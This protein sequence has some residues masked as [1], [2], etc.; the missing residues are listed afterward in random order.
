VIVMDKTE[1]RTEFVNWLKS[2]WD[3]SVDDGPDK[4]MES[5]FKAALHS[6]IDGNLC[7]EF[8][9]TDKVIEIITNNVADI[10]AE[11]FERQSLYLSAD[12]KSATVT[13]GIGPLMATLP[14]KTL[15]D[16]TEFRET[17]DIDLEADASGCI[18][19]A[20][21]FIDAEF[22]PEELVSG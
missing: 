16:L 15:I 10:L 8:F 9:A 12:R 5:V 13:I 20:T 7:P 1:I 11:C 3:I 4:S 21:A 6:C 22:F 18:T 17:G 14:I 2:S 19:G